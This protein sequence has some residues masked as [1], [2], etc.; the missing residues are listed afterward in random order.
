[1]SKLKFLYRKARLKDVRDIKRIESDCGLSPWSVKDY[2][3]EIGKNPDFIICE[4]EEKIIGFIL[5][6]L[7]THIEYPIKNNKST[8]LNKEIIEAEILNISVMKEFRRNNIG[9]NLM[10]LI[11]DKLESYDEY[12]IILDV[13]VS[14]NAAIKF[15]QIFNFEIISRRKDLYSNPVEDGYFMK[16]EKN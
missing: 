3:Q 2:E 11:L 12:S 13:R 10:K 5:A 16:L 4:F 14:N 8:F 9:L 15:Y 7:I 1:M 6:R